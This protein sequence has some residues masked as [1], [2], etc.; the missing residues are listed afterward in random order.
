[1]FFNLPIQTLKK[2]WLYSFLLSSFFLL[3]MTYFDSFLTNEVS[4]F[5]IVSFELAKDLAKAKDILKSWN[6]KATQFAYYSLYFDFLFMLSYG[7][8]LAYSVLFWGKRIWQK[9]VAWTSFLVKLIFIAVVFDAIENI[10]LLQLMFG[11]LNILWSEMAFY[12][13]SAKF[14]I[15]TIVLIYLFIGFVFFIIQKT[16]K[17][18]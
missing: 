13:A 8:F 2:R 6:A 5:G 17:K 15:L 9:S 10:A 11:K 3:L 16:I 4:P 7:A 14:F 1:M 12:F 18:L